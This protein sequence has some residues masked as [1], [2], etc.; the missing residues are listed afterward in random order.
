MAF[1][2]PGL[3]KSKAFGVGAFKR[4]NV[5]YDRM[6]E[7]AE[8]YKLAAQKR[9]AELFEEHK[10]VTAKLKIENQHKISVSYT[11]LTLPTKRIV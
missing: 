5:R 8:K 6:A 7:N 10:N 2:M 9:G 3:L 1:R 11:H 4:I